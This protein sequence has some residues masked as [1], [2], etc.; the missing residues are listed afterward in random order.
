MAT[1]VWQIAFSK[2]DKQGAAF[3]HSCQIHCQKNSRPNY[4]SVPDKIMGEGTYSLLCIPL[5]FCSDV[6]L[7]IEIIQT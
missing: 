6:T 3:A 1:C 5:F 2:K 7:H 4:Q